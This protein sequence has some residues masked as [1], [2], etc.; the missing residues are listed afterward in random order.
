MTS[1]GDTLPSSALTLPD[2]VLAAFCRTHGLTPSMVAVS[3]LSLDHP[4]FKIDAGSS[5]WAIKRAVNAARDLRAA[6]LFKCCGVPCL[7]LAPLNGDWTVATFIDLPTIETHLPNVSSG[8]W[9]ELCRWLGVATVQADLIG[10]RDRNLRNMLV[11]ADAGRIVLIDYEGAFQASV[12]G[13]IFNPGKYQ[14]YL[15]R[16]MLVNVMEAAGV[17]RGADLASLLGAFEAGIVAEQSRLASLLSAQL[18][19]TS[20]T[21]RER[22]VVRTRQRSARLIVRLAGKFLHQAING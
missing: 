16:R 6:E 1:T 20:L 11:D 22:W 5:V 21:P 19:L 8:D 9:P 10:L 17:S 14:S 18:A 3:P 2:P 4:V 12:S 7:E 13:R 15:V